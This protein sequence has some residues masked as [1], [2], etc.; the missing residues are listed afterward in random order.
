MKKY[1]ALRSLWRVTEWKDGCI[2]KTEFVGNLWV[3]L[4]SDMRDPA[5]PDGHIYGS[6]STKANIYPQIRV[7][8][9]EE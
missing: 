9:G 6:I 5:P 7:K 4:D 3:E 8:K 1:E 2:L